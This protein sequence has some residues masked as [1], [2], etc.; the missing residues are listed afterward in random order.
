MRFALPYCVSIFCERKALR[1]NDQRNDHLH[2]VAAL[3]AAV[4]V[5]TLVFIIARWIGFEIGAGQV[6]KQ[7]LEGGGEQILPAPAQMTE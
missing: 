2:A 1:R 4:A 3:V 6:I 7:H 5:T